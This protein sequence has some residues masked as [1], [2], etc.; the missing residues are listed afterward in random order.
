MRRIAS[1]L[2]FALI[3]GCTAMQQQKAQAPKPD[4]LQFKNLKV[5]APDMTRDAL[6][7]AM[8]GYSR[9][10]GVRCTHCHV[11]TATEPKEAMDFV[12][13]AKPEKNVAR[14][15]IRMTRAINADY[16]SKVNEHGDT[17]SCGTCHRGHAVPEAFNPPAPPARPE[18]QTPAPA[19]PT[20]NPNS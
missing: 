11:Q 20:P 8:R 5:L 2:F 7:S 15:M 10:L 9:A 18:G 16:V 19:P 12:S 4:Q 14:T 13:D 1:V 17:V 3:L 6:I